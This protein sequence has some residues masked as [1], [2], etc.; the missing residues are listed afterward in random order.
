[1]DGLMFALVMFATSAVFL[2]IARP[3]RSYQRKQNMAAARRYLAERK[4][5]ET[6][7]FSDED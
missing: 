7:G 1:M 4:A 6:D 3:T 5:M 2:L